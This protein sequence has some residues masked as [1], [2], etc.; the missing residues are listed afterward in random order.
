MYML[1]FG[2]TSDQAQSPLGMLPE[3]LKRAEV[4]TGITAKMALISK[5]QQTSLK[6]RG[7]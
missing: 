2:L 4:N 6:S 7:H 3:V 5:I 1:S